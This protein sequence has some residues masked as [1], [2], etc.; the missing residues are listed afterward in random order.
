MT[1]FHASVGQGDRK[2]IIGNVDIGEVTGDMPRNL[3]K[4]TKT[5][6]L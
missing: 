4:V 3:N 2:L 6:V 1:T 5:A